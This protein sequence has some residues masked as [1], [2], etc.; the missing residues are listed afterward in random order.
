MSA[1]SSH[2]AYTLSNTEIAQQ[3]DERL[4]FVAQNL[5]PYAFKGADGEPVVVCQQLDVGELS[6]T[7]TGAQTIEVAVKLYGYDNQL[8]FWKEYGLPYGA[9]ARPGKKVVPADSGP[10]NPSE[11]EGCPDL[12]A[13]MCGFDSIF[14]KFISELPNEYGLPETVESPYENVIQLADHLSA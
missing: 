10:S 8:G 14:S 2:E 4:L 3:T 9:L 7:R 13:F 1:A 6:Y 11:F 12:T 5:P